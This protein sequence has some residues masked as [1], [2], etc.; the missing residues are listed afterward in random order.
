MKTLRSLP[1]IL[2]ALAAFS[3]AIWLLG[4]SAIPHERITD[5]VLGFCTLALYV[6]FVRNDFVGRQRILEKLKKGSNDTED[7]KFRSERDVRAAIREAS[8]VCWYTEESKHP[9]QPERRVDL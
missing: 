8:R 6:M 5:W 9:R 4:R 3:A 7:N 2:A 1:R